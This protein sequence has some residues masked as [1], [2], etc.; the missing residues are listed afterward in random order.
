MKFKEY[1]AAAEEWFNV[2]FGWFFTNG[3]KAIQEAE[4]KQ[5]K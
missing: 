3:M 5:V 2:Q 1:I 4:R